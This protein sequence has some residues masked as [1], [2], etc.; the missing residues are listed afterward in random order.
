MAQL[1]QAS[2]LPKADQ[3]RVVRA[4]VVCT[5][6]FVPDCKILDLR[7]MSGCCTTSLPPTHSPFYCSLT[8]SPLNH[9]FT[10]HSPLIHSPLT[11][12]FTTHS[13]LI[14]SRTHTAEPHC[15]GASFQGVIQRELAGGP[16]RGDGGGDIG[17][18][19]HSACLQPWPHHAHLLQNILPALQQCA[20]GEI[21]VHV[22]VHC[23]HQA[24]VHVH[25]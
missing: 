11:H 24:H 8:H 25:V 20:S 9:S 13:P 23:M 15:T 22:H 16:V 4:L 10:T 18:E 1:Q 14:H 7:M 6:V 12:S 3:Q 21:H 19:G 17:R 5:R 2:T